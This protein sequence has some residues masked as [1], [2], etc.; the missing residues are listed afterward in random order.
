LNDQKKPLPI[1]DCDELVPMMTLKAGLEE[2]VNECDHEDDIKSCALT[3]KEE[4]E[5]VKRVVGSVTR[6]VGDIKRAETSKERKVTQEE[7][8]KDRADVK[9][10]KELSKAMEKREQKLGVERCWS[11]PAYLLGRQRSHH[12]DVS[13]DPGG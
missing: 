6:P 4:L 1:E 8:K 10:K 7:A 12:G 11:N 5:R 13:E 2:A 9:K 3:F